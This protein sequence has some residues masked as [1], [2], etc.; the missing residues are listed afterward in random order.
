MKF[1]RRAYHLTCNTSSKNKR[2]T[3]RIVIESSM[4]LCILSEAAYVTLSLV[5]K[6]KIT[7][8]PFEVCVSTYLDIVIPILK[9]LIGYGINL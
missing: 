2:K 9:D 8:Y 3:K 4:K 1:D 7:N 5:Y 6:N